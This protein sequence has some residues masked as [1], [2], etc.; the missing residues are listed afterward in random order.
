MKKRKIFI[1][2][3]YIFVGIL[4]ILSI[5]YF[6]NAYNK[7]NKNIENVK[8]EQI[9]KKIELEEIKRREIEEKEATD[10]RVEQQRFEKYEDVDNDKVKMQE[11]QSNIENEKNIIPHIDIN[12]NVKYVTYEDFGALGNGIQDDYIAI[13]K[14][15]EFA[16]KYNYDV[17]ATGEQYHIFNL[18]NNG[19]ITILTNTDW[20]GAKFIIHDEDIVG[21]ETRKEPIIE[22]RS[23][24]KTKIIEDKDILSKIEINKE[25]KRIPEL[26][27]YGKSL[28]KVYNSNKKQFIRTG[29]EQ[30]IG[31]EQQDIFEID[32]TGKLL[33][34]VQWDF[35]EITK[36][37]IMPIPKDT[38]IVQ[39]GTFQTNLSPYK[40][41]QETGYYNRNIV[42]DRSN[43]ILKNVKHILDNDS[44]T[45]A[46]YYGFIRIGNACEIT[47]SNCNLVAHKYENMSSYDLIIE[48][49]TNVKIESVTSDNITD[50]ERWGITGSNYTKDIT[51]EDCRLNRIDAHCGV[52][53]L[54]INNCQIGDK[55]ICVVGS[56]TLNIS[57]TTSV[58]TNAF[59]TLRDDYGSTWDGK[60]Y[61]KECSYTTSE[62]SKLIDFKVRYNN[63]KILHDYGYNKVLP[64]IYINNLFINDEKMLDSSSKFYIFYNSTNVTGQG[65]ENLIKS[66]YQLP[67]E[68][69]VEEYKTQTG[70]VIKPFLNVFE[71]FKKIDIKINIPNRAILQ[72]EDENSKKY[73]SG[74]LT[75]QS[76]HIQLDTVKNIENELMV[77]GE[78]IRDK[79]INLNKTG[80]Y[81]IIVNSTDI[82]GNHVQDTYLINIDKEPPK[83]KGVENNKIYNNP[84]MPILEDEDIQTAKLFLNDKEVEDYKVNTKISAYGKYKLEVIDRA[85]NTTTIL[86]EIKEKSIE[87]INEY[88]IIKEKYIKEILPNTTKKQFFDTAMIDKNLKLQ[89]Q[90]NELDEN[91]IIKTGDILTVGKNNYTLIIK[92]DVSKDGLTSITD[93]MKIKR[94]VIVASGLN[95]EQKEAADAN[96]DG[97]IDIK[98]VMNITRMI[99][100]DL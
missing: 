5:T 48:R 62:M 9:A 17:K 59:I 55:G 42:C 66:G 65:G 80:N 86:F 89:H 24:E 39:N 1:K 83:I 32:N 34:E 70:R 45:G 61:I 84:V 33:N 18:E 81:Q 52:H 27:G 94:Y 72:M 26:A 63:G 43:T 64:S 99:I 29:D 36:I 73:E 22:I 31:N 54:T 28:C 51:Y 49:A 58:A 44:I 50:S 41:E 23:T 96:S 79:E 16:N 57:N 100:N 71:E 90:N 14:T 91:D 11:E 53:N 46:P 75:N 68:I 78:I 47:I 25:T 20:N 88:K 4:L 35:K 74:S 19:Y 2:Q 77:N 8:L 56:G 60:I 93:I 10:I 7:N 40:K 37:I 13:K 30:N 12:T 38:I 6:L 15:H 87:D 67:S 82:A 92:G 76:I 85:T 3:K 95:E 69:I 98:D 97:K 21:L